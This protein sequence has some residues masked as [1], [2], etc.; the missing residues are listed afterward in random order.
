VLL[1]S[2]QLLDY[3]TIDMLDNGFLCVSNQLLR[4]SGVQSGPHDGHSSKQVI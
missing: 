4:N 2:G 3:G 1:Y